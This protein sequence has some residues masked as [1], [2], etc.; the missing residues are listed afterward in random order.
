[1]RAQGGGQFTRTSLSTDLGQRNLHTYSPCVYHQATEVAPFGRPEARAADVWRIL[2]PAMLDAYP[3]LRP[4][5]ACDVPT[6]VTIRFKKLVQ[7]RQELA[8]DDE[9][10]VSTIYFD[11][12]IGDRVWP[13]QEVNIKQAAGAGFEADLGALEVLGARLPRWTAQLSCVS[14]LR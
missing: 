6:N 13:N 14:R 11:V 12:V 2:T 3:M 7:D 5:G 8:T 4:E 10:M 1:M 9:S